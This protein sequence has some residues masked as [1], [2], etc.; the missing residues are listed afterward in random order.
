MEFRLF[1]VNAVRL[2]RHETN[3]CRAL[4][5]VAVRSGFWY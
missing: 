2:I 4:P 3:C 5:G 1:V